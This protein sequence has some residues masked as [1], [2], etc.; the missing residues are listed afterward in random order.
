MPRQLGHTPPHE[1][2]EGE[3]HCFPA[4]GVTAPACGRLIARRRTMDERAIT[5]RTVVQGSAA[6]AGMAALGALP[7]RA[8]AAPVA[9]GET[10]IPWLDQP[11][12]FPFAPAPA[13]TQLVWEELGSQI[14]PDEKFFTVAH[15]GMQII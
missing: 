15:H 12:P 14:T 2:C 3:R 4:T 1:L 7:L 13:A 10:V 11:P 6:L 9:A 5:R 8:P